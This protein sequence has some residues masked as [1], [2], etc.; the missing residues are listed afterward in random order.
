MAFFKNQSSDLRWL[1]VFWYA[2]S[3]YASIFLESLSLEYN[4]VHLYTAT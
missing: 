2:H 1:L 3:L 4:E